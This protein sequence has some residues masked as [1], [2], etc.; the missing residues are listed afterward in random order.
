VSEAIP[1]DALWIA[2]IMLGAL[3]LYALLGG[4]DYGG[5][6]WD[7]FARGPRA[8]AQ[9]R[10]IA[11]A[12]GPVWEANHVWLIFVV[13]LLFTAF[14]PAF[15][16]IA[17]A[18]HVPIALMLLGVVLRGTSFTF[19]HYDRQDDAVQRRWGRMFAISSLFTPICLGICLGAISTG[20]IHAQDGVL[21]SGF[22]SPWLGPFPLAVGT[23]ALAAFAFLA[24]VYLVLETDDDALRDDFRRR[25]VIAA[26]IM[27]GLA[28]VV[29]GLSRHSAPLVWAGLTS[30]AWSLP[31][32]IAAGASAG[33][34]I[35]TLATRHFHAARILAAAHV[36]LLLAGW[37]LAQFPFLVPPDLSIATAAAPARVLRMVLWT[38]AAGA[39][40]LIPSLLYLFRVFKMRPPRRTD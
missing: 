21:T 5:G 13:V 20:G 6:V 11:A 40:I 2:A 4:A 1:T 10:L 7:L 3:V 26:L 15:A 18:L 34:A 29:F 19:R 39:V 36:A 35:A 17:T 12:I 28:G 9:R 37:A 24:A 31:L 27:V 14:P 23:L 30:R 25:A 8:A 33:S 32:V 22:V 16:I 38:V